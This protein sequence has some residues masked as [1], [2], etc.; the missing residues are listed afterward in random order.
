VDMVDVHRQIDEQHA[1][2]QDQSDTG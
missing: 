1:D 2:H